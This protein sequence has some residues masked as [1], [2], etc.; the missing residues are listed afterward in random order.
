METQNIVL[1]TID[2]LRADAVQHMPNLLTLGNGGGVFQ[3]YSNGPS[4][5]FSFPSIFNINYHPFYDETKI[6]SPTI[7]ENYRN[8]GYKTVGIVA[9]NPYIS[10][11]SGYN[12]GFI[13]FEDYMSELRTNKRSTTSNIIQKLPNLFRDFKNIYKWYFKSDIT[14]SNG[15]ITAV[16]DS[17]DSINGQEPFF[18]WL[19]L[20]DTHY[21]YTPPLK[22]TEFS[23]LDIVKLNHFRKIHRL[24]KS[25]DKNKLL[26]LKKLYADCVRWTDQVLNNFFMTLKEHDL[27]EKTDILVTA[28]HGEG[29][30]EHGFL[31]H[32]AQLYEELVRVPLVVKIQ[33]MKNKKIKFTEL[34]DVPKILD[35]EISSHNE[36]IKNNK[37]ENKI[38][39]LR[40]RHAGD[41]S[42]MKGD[43][44]LI[45][46]PDK[47]KYNIYGIVSGKYKIIYDD[48]DGKIE[49]YNLIKDPKEKKDISKKRKKFI[50][51]FL[52]EYPFKKS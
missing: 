45:G 30:Y 11:L 31:G 4:T 20:M 14:S 16:E 23:P 44:N 8:I 37:I 24:K 41:R 34:R 32:P 5:P 2:S 29:F 52:E 17:I 12:K 39:P 18:L 47:L 22:E 25:N 36:E 40:A 35:N 38:I 43:I 1:I 51:K 46:N 9:N 26:Q 19:H 21:P 50:Q 13:H 6:R 33:G 15:S 48:E 28:D 27:W 3:V 49:L 10:N 7:V 42:C